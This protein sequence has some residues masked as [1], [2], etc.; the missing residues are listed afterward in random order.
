[1]MLVA[2]MLA[3]LSTHFSS[4]YW[5]ELGDIRSGIITKRKYFSHTSID[6]KQNIL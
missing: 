4:W 6:I 3:V 2:P 5:I 1:M